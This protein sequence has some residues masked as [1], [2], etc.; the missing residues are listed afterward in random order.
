MRAKAGRALERGIPWLAPLGLLMGSW[1]RVDREL[2]AA[3]GT[4]VLAIGGATLGGSGRSALALSCAEYMY[5]G[6]AR[7]AVVG[8]AYRA[9][10]GRAR[11]VSP[12]DPLEL[13]GDEA[14]ML[15]RALGPRAK[16]VVAPRRQDALLLAE[17]LADVV[18]LDGVLQTSPAR[19][20]LSLLAVRDESPWGSSRVLPAGD[21]RAPIAAL[22][23]ACDHVVRVRIA[24][25][26]E[27]ARLAGAR[28]GLVSAIARPERLVL[29]LAR[30]GLQ[31]V[32]HVDMGDHGPLHE[33]SVRR[34]IARAEP[35]AA[36]L[37]TPKCTEHVLPLEEFL[38]SRRTPLVRLEGRAALPDHLISAL[39]GLLDVAKAPPTS[40]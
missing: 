19:A 23:A 9:R 40:S 22:T 12:L 34:A 26:E 11:V 33:A 7:V 6:G 25:G 39:N 17:S 15:A 1:V 10:P 14:R 28:V 5:K 21:L 18:I 35:V 31:V 8:H 37:A 4:R 38:A 29:A 13:V 32:S 24:L 27:A 20:T 3:M 2:R 36:W 30:A 16:V